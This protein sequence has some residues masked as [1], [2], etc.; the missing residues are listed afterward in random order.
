[1]MTILYICRKHG[2]GFMDYV[3]DIFSGRDNLPGLAELIPQKA[4]ALSPI[5]EKVR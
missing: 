4:S 1:M 2:I 3:K 5:N